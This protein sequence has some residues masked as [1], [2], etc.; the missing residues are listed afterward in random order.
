[1]KPIS[2][3]EVRDFGARWF[4]A[5]HSQLPIE[6]QRKFFAPGVNIETWAGVT[7]P[8]EKQFA[9]HVHLTNESHKVLTMK[10]EHRPD[11]RV[12][13]VSK[14]HWEATKT[15]GGPGPKLILAD[16]G[17]DWIVGRGP[18]GPLRYAHYLTNSMTHLSG[19]AELDLGK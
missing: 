5:A 17:E 12:H 19:S 1:M 9:F 11:G 14:F 10:I 7:L 6:L 8:L 16:C 13:V 3:E 18:D 15:D 2:D 4:E